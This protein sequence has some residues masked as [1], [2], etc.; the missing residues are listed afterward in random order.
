MLL[1]RTIASDATY[2]VADNRIASVG[3]AELR[4]QRISHA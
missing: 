4:R 3:P 1:K 2:H